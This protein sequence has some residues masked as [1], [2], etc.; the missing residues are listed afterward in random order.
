MLCDSAL[1]RTPKD[2]WLLTLGP[3]QFPIKSMEGFPF[4][5]MGAGV[6]LIILLN[7]LSVSGTGV[8]FCFFIETLLF[9]YC[10]YICRVPQRSAGFG[11]G[12]GLKI[13]IL[14]L[15][16]VICIWLFSGVPVH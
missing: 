7:S 1:C 10:P 11:P 9:S 2:A 4:T 12:F 5:S 14:L 13:H 3:V 15:S 6:G 16:G 8:L